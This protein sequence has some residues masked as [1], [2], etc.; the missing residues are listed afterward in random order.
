M[1]INR[2]RF[3]AT[4]GGV[5]LA[6]PFLRPGMAHA[7]EYSY[8]Y[9]NNFP[10]GHPMNTQMEA[11][12]KRISEETDGRF[13]LKIFPNNQLGSDTDTLNQ[14]RSGAVEFF[15]LSGLILS[16]L[17]PVASI[18]G[19]G[20]A[21]KDIDQVWQAMDG[22][23]GAYVREQIRANRLEVM[24]RI[25]NN[26]FRQ[27]T[28]S[29]RPIEGPDDLAGLKIRVPVS[30]LWTSMFQ[31]LGCAP[32]SINWNEVYTSLQTGVVDA[33]ENPLS[34]IDVGKLYEVQTYCS[35]T[36]HMWDGF[37]MLANP[38]AWRALPDDL[39]E[40]VA[41][42]INQAALDQREDLTQLNATLQSELEKYGLIFNKPDTAAIRDKLREAGFYSE[43]RST[44][45]DEAWALLEQVSGSLA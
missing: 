22:E 32:V 4:A 2:R 13:E 26:G 31:A 25:F 11:A 29:S 45:G 12:A 9:A 35:M 28:T 14:V 6:A 20:F 21:F 39:Q 40:I 38:R 43:W 34:T 24:D 42:N 37:W 10:V 33:Q 1:T 36:N 30:P 19:M 27:I 15:T 5:L 23:L 3:V 7:A 16:S 41:R 17:V 8:K 44:Y 18:N